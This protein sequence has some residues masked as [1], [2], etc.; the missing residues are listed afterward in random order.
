M[1]SVSVG[2]LSACYEGD[3]VDD[4]ERV[5]ILVSFVNARPKHFFCVSAATARI[6]FQANAGI[7]LL[8][9]QQRGQFFQNSLIGFYRQHGSPSCFG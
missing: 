5:F 4:G 2:Q 7:R 9:A 1:I 3:A 8:I 6:F